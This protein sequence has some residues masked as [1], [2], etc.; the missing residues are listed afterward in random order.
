[1]ATSESSAELLRAQ[2][3]IWNQ[4]FNFKNSASLKCAIQLGIPDVIQKY[5]KPITLCDLTSALPI[6]PFKAPYIKRLM[7][8]LTNAGVFAQEKGGYYTLTSAGRL[9][10]E[11]EP[12]NA[13]GF[14]LMNLDPAMMKP[15]NVLSEWFQ[16]DDL[17]P[18]DTAHG[19][20]F[21]D[22][23][24][25]EPKLGKLFK[26]VMASDSQLIT[27]V[28]TK[29]CGYVF[30]GLTSLVDVGGGTG[31]VAR[32]IA[33]TFPNLKCTVFDL[34][35]VVANQ[36]ETQNLDFVAG[37]MFEKVPP[38]NAILLKWI[39][40]DWSDEDCLKIL[41]N[42]KKAIP[43]KDEG[44]KLIVIDM[45]MESQI[46]DEESVEAQICSDMQMLV[47]FRAKERTEKEWTTLFRNAGFS[48]C[49]VFPV[50]GARSLIEV[51]P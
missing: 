8:I 26:E 18:F 22:Y 43:R 36:E 23:N 31:T 25:D 29:E 39:L 46:E 38:A 1:M 5:G 6:N 4:T 50:L 21:W 47:L 35:H 15:W 34:P 40:H 48:N 28:L 17:A 12:M 37:D 11:N 3:H 16:N 49:K 32:S 20:N 13:R 41:K 27:M 14:V 2:T 42:C 44:G 10:V 7:Q 9:L 33:E 24:A 19:R 45:V 30:E 51:Y